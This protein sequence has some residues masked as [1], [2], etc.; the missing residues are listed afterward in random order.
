M[1]EFAASIFKAE[2]ADSSKMLVLI[3]Q[4]THC[5][6]ME[7]PV[8][9]TRNNFRL[10]VPSL[11][12]YQQQH[13]K[14]DR[15]PAKSQVV[16]TNRARDSITKP[17]VIVPAASTT[18]GDPVLQRKL[19]DTVLKTGKCCCKVHYSGWVYRGSSDILYDV[20]KI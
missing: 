12:C 11:V 2:A 1:E 8:I 10:N 7:K 4:T 13:K 16:T 19:S 17:A 14:P 5:H 18:K 3:Y 6:T 20:R 15:P 9:L